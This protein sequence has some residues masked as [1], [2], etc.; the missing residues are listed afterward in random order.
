MRFSP[1]RYVHAGA[2]AG[3]RQAAMALCAAT[4]LAGAGAAPAVA[5]TNSST[6][7]SSQVLCNV[8]LFSPGAH[9]DGCHNVQVADQGL[10]KTGTTN[11][12]LIDYLR[13]D[14]L[15]LLP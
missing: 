9:P 14:L 12:G 13:A 8:V 15:G 6:E 1:D 2:G 4:L 11:A 5:D 7:K 10:V 3:L